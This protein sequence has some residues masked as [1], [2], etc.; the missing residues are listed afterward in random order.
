M[1]RWSQIAQHLP[2]RT[3]NEIKNHWHSYLKKKI[4]VK[5]DE[6]HLQMPSN[7]DSVGSMNSTNF[8]TDHTQSY[9][10]TEHTKS[11]ASQIPE[12]F[13]RTK[14]GQS[15]LPRLLFAEW[16]SL[17]NSPGESFTNH[18][19]LQV[20]RDDH[21]YHTSSQDSLV[22]S[23]LNEGNFGGDQYQNDRS[24]F[25]TSEIYSSQFDFEHQISG[26]GLVRCLSRDDLCSAFSI[27]DDMLSN[28]NFF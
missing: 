19:E 21:Y 4:N 17:D 5:A 23:L 18:A 24:E 14:E 27:D 20:P 10:T 7:S 26:N 11:A 9:D 22:S 28:E 12:I 2:G 1:I 15:S 3:D 8:P 6:S 16:L 25:S 13:N